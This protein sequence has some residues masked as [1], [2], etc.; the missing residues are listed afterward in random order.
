MIIVAIRE[1]AII[2]HE[3]K[4]Q[5]SRSREKFKIFKISNQFVVILSMKKRLWTF[6][7][8]ENLKKT[9]RKYQKIVVSPISSFSQKKLFQ[10]LNFAQ[11]FPRLVNFLKQKNKIALELANT[12]CSLLEEKKF[13]KIS[14]NYLPKLV[15]S[16]WTLLYFFNVIKIVK[17]NFACCIF[18]FYFYI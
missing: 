9:R 10:N 13:F 15:L 7:V 14:K 12:A 5:Y 8:Q 3:I 18:Q 17:T 4:T 16:Q 2:S 1:M 11:I 6:C